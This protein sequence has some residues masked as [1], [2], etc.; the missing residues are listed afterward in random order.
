[1]FEEDRLY[2]SP[3]SNLLF[4]GKIFLTITFLCFSDIFNEDQLFIVFEFADAGSDLEN[5]TVSKHVYSPIEACSC[6]NLFWS[7]RTSENIFKI[8]HN[9]FGVFGEDLLVWL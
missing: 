7:C 9:L 2:Q 6:L 5:H 1:M 8:E 4:I 3:L